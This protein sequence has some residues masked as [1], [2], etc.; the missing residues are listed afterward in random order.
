MA[1][2]DADIKLKVAVEN[3][4]ASVRKVE[5]AFKK[6]QD[7][8]VK[9][10][11]DGQNELKSLGNS[12]K[13]LSQIVKTSG[14]VTA[15]AAITGSLQSLNNLP[16]IGGGLNTSALGKAVSQLGAFSNAAVDAAASAPALAAGIAATTAALIAFA[17]QIA[18]ATKDTLK[19]ARVAAEAQVPIKNLFTMLGAASSS[20]N[21]GGFGD[22]AAGVE[23]FRRRINELNESVSNL[24]QRS[25]KLKNTL[26]NFNSGSATAEK[27]ATKL[28][29]VNARLNNELREQ[30]DLLRRVSGV[31][32]TEL[33]SSKGRNSIATRQK[34][35]EFRAKQASEALRVQQAL[36]QLE[37]RS[38]SSL[39]K[40][41][42]IEVRR[43]DLI[44]K[45][46]NSEQQAANTAR[47]A[48]DSK[49][50]SLERQLQIE[51][52]IANVRSQRAAREAS[53]RAQFLAGNPNQY[54]QGAV[55]PQSGRF[56]AIQASTR[57]TQQRLSL[58]KQLQ[59]VA[60]GTRFEFVKQVAVLQQL[61]KIGNQINK[62][63]EQ[64]LKNQRRLNR[65]LKVKEGRAAAESKKRLGES[66]A[67]GVGFP[68]L[69]GGGA[70]SVVG[71]GL[72]SFAGDG[73]GG[74]ILGGAIGQSIDGF[75]QSIGELGQALNPVTADVGRIVESAGLANT[76]LG[77]TITELESTAGSAIA[78]QEATKE[79]ER[80]V[81]QDGVAALRE[82]GDRFTTFGNQLAEFFTQVQ[83]A[84]AKLLQETPTERDLRTTGETIFQARRSDNTEIQDAVSRLDNSSVPNERLAI[85]QEIVALVEQEADAR[86]R[87]LELL[88]T[89]TGEAAAKRREIE[90]TVAEKQIELELEQLNAA[91]NDETRIALEQK[92]AFQQLMTEQQALYN[93]FARDQISIDVLRIKLAGARLDFETKIA[94]IANAATAANIKA[95]RVRT[96]GGGGGGGID[97]EAQTQKAI[98]AQLTKQFEL[99]TKLA[100]IGVTK[101]DKA[102]I[103]L[104]S[105]EERLALK[106]KELELSKEDD[107]IKEIK[108]QNLN[109]ETEILRK[110][111]E[112]QR[113][114]LQLENQVNALKGDQKIAGLQR[115]LDQ[116]LA[117]LTLPTGDAF[118][119]ERNQLALEQQQRYTNAITEVNDLIAQQQ[120]L[121]TSSDAAIAEAATKKLEILERQKGVY[122]TMLPAI[123]Q[124][125]Q[126]QLKFNQTLSLVEGPVNAFV[127]GI[128]S[129]LQGIIDG[130]MTAEEAFANML[131]GMA[132]ALIQTATQ[133]IAQYI[134]IGIARAFA[135][136]GGGGGGAFGSGASAPLT[137]GLDFSGAFAGGF[138]TGGFV[139][140]NRV[141]MVGEQGPEL[142]QSGPTGTTVT[143]NPDTQSALE[144]FSPSNAD[145]SQSMSSTPAINY[146]G[147][148]LKFNSEDYIPRSEANN[149]IDAGA[150]QGEQRAINRLRQS[151]SSRQKIGI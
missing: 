117:G 59:Q 38:V 23:E 58:N 45:R 136:M 114:R 116:E 10:K 109:A 43:V 91:A 57:A 107:R 2:F 86:E 82:F 147:P 48:D 1:Q 149:L 77:K 120:I 81:G 66:L 101:I 134:A 145:M 98:A 132:D 78:L 106:T 36:Q 62:S 40:V 87:E 139:G 124:A 130:T 144:R 123:A 68:L 129:G 55:G 42:D 72:G 95:N 137:G 133:M 135:G 20:G 71:S 4:E 73:F 121:A 46:A 56:D 19:I 21:L 63:T 143:N 53:Q 15:V 47:A 24:S 75:V 7:Y 103:Q 146:N 31:N 115:G 79:L 92:L 119:D 84:I 27:I 16:L 3:L 37:Q 113:E 25:D 60:A 80:V 29:A 150:K 94:K 17:P 32:V 108:L 97:K 148:L 100:T 105:L 41:L 88:A 18:R 39:T 14:I 93:Q 142:I 5:N 26:N 70:G 89:S 76:E 128:T 83:V 49:I 118:G 9:L 51:E 112:L 33:E 85:Q 44:Q 127:S 131:K 64:E 12:F 54:G 35:D 141:A 138:A 30:A 22:A 110:Q 111:L 65:E 67:L 50:R 69:F 8:R 125:E 126:Q 11:V 13:R 74:Q 28:V 34:A 122:E 61:A 151:R 52:R 99:E 102:N 104:N 90:A 6:V 96:G 140:P